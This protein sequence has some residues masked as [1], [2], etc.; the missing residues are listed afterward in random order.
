MVGEAGFE[1]AT[2][3]PKASRARL[4]NSRRVYATCLLPQQASCPLTRSTHGVISH[5]PD[6]R[7]LDQCGVVTALR[8]SPGIPQP[9]LRPRVDHLQ[10]D[11]T[12]TSQ[13]SQ[14]MNT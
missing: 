12:I 8:E 9:V 14:E 10:C 4:P 7:G 6:H 1:P 2:P 13:I 5:P 11:V 3:W